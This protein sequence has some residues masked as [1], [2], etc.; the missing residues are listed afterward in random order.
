MSM[1]RFSLSGANSSSASSVSFR[2]V[3]LSYWTG[4]ESFG[5]SLSRTVR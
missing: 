1:G 5:T 3:I 4:I 2:P